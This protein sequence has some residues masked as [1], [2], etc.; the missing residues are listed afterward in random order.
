MGQLDSTC[1][2]PPRARCAA[3]RPPGLHTL[4]RVSDWLREPYWRCHELIHVLT[5]NNNV[6]VPLPGVRLI[7]HVYTRTSAVI[8]LV[9][10]TAK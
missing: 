10:L 6:K 7:T 8:Q 9:F 4:S 1:R 5:H 3:P 2:A